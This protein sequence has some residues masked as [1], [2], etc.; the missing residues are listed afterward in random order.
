MRRNLSSRQSGFTIIELL[1][2]TL[3]FSLIMTII[4]VA[5]VQISRTYYRGIV[6]T[7]TQNT[8]RNIMDTVS[9]SIQFDG[10]TFSQLQP[11]SIIGDATGYP[12]AATRDEGIIC[13]GNHVFAYHLYQEQVE[14]ASSHGLTSGTDPCQTTGPLRYIGQELLSTNMRLTQ[15]EVTPLQNS[16]YNI[17]IGV[18][19]G[20][21]DLLCVSSNNSGNGADCSSSDAATY[22]QIKSPDIA[23][24]PQAGREFCAVSK[25]ST[26]VQRRVQ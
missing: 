5:V 9:Q 10:G 24:K 22:A 16:F 21:L 7:N 6:T 2:A 18:A 23:C 3:V 25:F 19:Y 11:R 14:S 8:A 26:I 20:D 1:V 12:A 13:I 4:A 15:F 17:K